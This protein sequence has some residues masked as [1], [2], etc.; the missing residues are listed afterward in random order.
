MPPR[1]LDGAGHGKLPVQL[2]ENQRRGRAIVDEVIGDEHGLERRFDESAL[3][4]RLGEKTRDDGGETP[5]SRL[6]VRYRRGLQT[7]AE[8][9]R[10][11][12]R[13]G[14]ATVEGIADRHRNPTTERVKQ[15]LRHDPLGRTVVGPHASPPSHRFRSHR[16]SLD[17][18][19]AQPHHPSS[20]HGRVT[21][22]SRNI[23]SRPCFA[24][25]RA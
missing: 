19:H 10:A 7:V 12:R 18:S 20:E 14:V 23:P 24:D 2:R 16:S 21:H 15:D 4:F 3:G 11:H 1:A 17:S 6:G 5:K 13:Q 8:V 25:I 22:D 9:A